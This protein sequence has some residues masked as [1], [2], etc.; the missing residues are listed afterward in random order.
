MLDCSPF[1]R[2]PSRRFVRPSSLEAC[3]R[4]VV[5]VGILLFV[6]PAL[7]ADGPTP[8]PQWRGPEF[9]GYQAD[10]D[11]PLEFS[12][13][14]NLRFKKAV[15][16]AGLASPI[17]YDG[18]VYLL[19]AEAADAAAEEA[20]RL[21]A[22]EKAEKKE[23]PPAVE[24]VAQAFKLLAYSA[25]TGELLWQRTASEHVPHESHYLDASWASATPATDGERIY[26]HFGSNGTYVY[27]I[28]GELLWKKDL[29]NMTTRNGFGEGTSPL[30][31]QDLLIIP[32]DHEG[33]SF[34]VALD[35]KTGDERWRVAR[36]D[37]ASSWVT[38]IVVDPDGAGDAGPQ[39][40]LPGTGK[41]RAYD[42]R[43]GA[44]IWSLGG[45]TKNTIPSP[46]SRHGKVYMM[47]GFRG[48][49]L[50]AVDLKQAKGDLTDSP[51]V[52]FTFDRHTPYV[53]SPTLIDDNLCFIKNTKNVFT[54]L[55]ADTGAVR[56]T[57]VRLP[58][59]QNVYASPVGARDR[60]YIFDKDGSAVVV[61]N[62]AAF[63][64][65]AES[66][67]D[68]PVDAS[69]A[70]YGDSL[71]VRSRGHLYRFAE[72]APAPDAGTKPGAGGA[73]SDAE[74]RQETR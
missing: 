49:V 21:K 40:I 6:G 42:P 18:V 11:P 22:A 71:F 64:V 39:L 31:W 41:S 48:T 44:E 50:Q 2:R 51:A 46:V 47:S 19:T 57:E 52:A 56:F 9:N 63:E 20:S 25:E 17:V 4:T 65:L 23:W 1:R 45:M 55:D 54:C 67:L 60:I 70:I 10:G 12:E 62:G 7:Q 73:E 72:T 32:W 16:G 13:T 8:W 5:A 34:L 66:Q 59:I 35:K 58:G 3:R 28:D 53:P 38:P 74:S 29:G 61:K 26:A 36:P 24:P 30:L 69:P 27:A 33:D 15:P 14:K 37:E 43:T 68:E